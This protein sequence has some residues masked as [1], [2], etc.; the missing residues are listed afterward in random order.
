MISILIPT[1]QYS[2]YPLVKKVH[3]LI[4]KENIDFEIL[5]YDDC[6]PKEIIENKKINQLD[7]AYYKVLPKNSGR[8]TM[9]NLLADNAKFE[10]LLFLDADVMPIKDDFIGNYL[11]FFSEKYDIIYG[12]IKY[13][14]KKPKATQLLRWHYGNSRESLSCEK[15]TEN[16]YLSFLTLNFLARKSIFQKIRFDEDIPNLRHEDTLFS[17]HLQSFKVPILHINNPVYHLGIESSLE[18]LKKSIESVEGALYLK[19]NDLI[20]SNYI[21]ILSFHEKLKKLKLDYL[22]D[23]LIRKNLKQIEVNLLGNKPSL[24]LFDLYRLYHLIQ[25]EKNA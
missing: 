10:W 5:V 15:R 4:T 12:G 23:R 24:L 25:F 19:K 17:Y 7:N 20:D 1:Y 8:S 21:R 14:P 18:F 6:S 16:P 13:T 2:V 22:I 3:Q 11:K 9:R